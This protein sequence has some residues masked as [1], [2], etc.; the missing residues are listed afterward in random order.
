[1]RH[2]TPIVADLSAITTP[3]T[4]SLVPVG[5]KRQGKRKWYRETPEMVQMFFLQGSQFGP[6]N[7]LII[8]GNVRR[9]EE[10]PTLAYKNFDIHGLV[11]NLSRDRQEFLG[12]LDQEKFVDSETERSAVI[13]DALTGPVAAFLKEFDTE[14]GTL[15]FFRR[16]DNRNAFDIL[17]HTEKLMRE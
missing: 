12:A 11:H 15:R 13:E 3:I 14:A 6:Q 2:D 10:T 5:F 16:T 7:Q 9:L 8:L 17:P 4:E 1:M